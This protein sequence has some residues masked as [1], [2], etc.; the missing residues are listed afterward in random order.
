M[1]T[2][3]LETTPDLAGCHLAGQHV[4]TDIAIGRTGDGE[5]NW[6]I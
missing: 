6:L 3:D 5:Q 4:D 1:R 2:K